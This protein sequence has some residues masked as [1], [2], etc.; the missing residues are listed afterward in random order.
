MIEDILEG[1]SSYRGR[2]RGYDLVAD[3]V[4]HL[5]WSK[6][7]RHAWGVC[8]LRGVLEA[9]QRGQRVSRGVRQGPAPLRKLRPPVITLST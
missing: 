2:D 6:A 1:M 5:V 9:R 7:A 4:Q 3:E 8:V